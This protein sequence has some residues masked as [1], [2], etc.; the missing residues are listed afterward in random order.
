MSSALTKRIVLTAEPKDRPYELRDAQVRGPI[1]RVQPSGHKAWIVTWAHGKRRT[2][3][4]VEHLALPFAK[5]AVSE[6]QGRTVAGVKVG[7]R[8]ADTRAA[9]E[10]AGYMGTRISNDAGTE[11]GTLHNVPSMKMDVRVMD[12]GPKHPPRVW[13]TREGTP[14]QP[15]IPENGKNFGGIP[16]GEQ[17]TGSHIYYRDKL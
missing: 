2:L 8:P 9:L 3:G 6:M 11:S 15:V 16:K 7:D 17:C 1:L 12:G 10:D 5:A 4:S 14:R 13:V